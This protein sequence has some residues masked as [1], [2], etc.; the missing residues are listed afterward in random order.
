MTNTKHKSDREL[1]GQGICNTI[2]PFFNGIPA[3]AAIARS[4]VNIREG[5]KT[6]V[7]GIIHA[8]ILLL[9][10]LLFSPIASHIP[11]AFLAGI[12][13]FVSVR[14]INLHEFKTIMK[15]S[16]LETIVLIAT[17]SLTVLTDLVFAVEVGMVLAIFLVFVRLTNIIDVHP[18][19]HY[20]PD[21]AINNIIAANPNLQNTVAVYTINGPFFFGTMNL[22]DKKITEQLDEKKPVIVLRMKYVPFIDSTGAIRLNDFIHERLKRKGIVLLSGLH[23]E[24]RKTLDDNEEF[25]KMFKPQHIFRKT[26]DALM[27]LERNYHHLLLEQN[28][29]E[30]K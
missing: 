21:S 8:L 20:G 27:Y 10:V 18:M 1:I 4:A 22:F 29:K 17:F 26:I 9:I 30:K 14:M 7:A 15:I 23:P 24:V 13:M 2:V 19:S 11:K 6:R 12:L 25:R 28:G 5:A 3:T 16:R